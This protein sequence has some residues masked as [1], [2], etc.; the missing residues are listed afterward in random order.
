MIC[1][2]CGS[3]SEQGQYCRKCG[4]LLIDNEART[5]P[6]ASPMD[7]GDI[8]IEIK[9]ELRQQKTT[10]FVI[11]YVDVDQA[12]NLPPGSTEKYIEQAAEES[13]MEI[14]TKGSTRAE[15]RRRPARVLRA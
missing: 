5:I 4:S 9:G 10:P 15:I 8:L 6:I 13:N 1:S 7:K 2:N 3:A 12:H 14:I 11:T